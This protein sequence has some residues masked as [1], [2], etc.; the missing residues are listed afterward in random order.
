MRRAK[1]PNRRT[2]FLAL[3]SDARRVKRE[4][5]SSLLKK[6][7]SRL[8]SI[9][10]FART[11]SPY[12]RQLYRDLPARIV[13]P[14]QLPVTNKPK[15]MA[16]FDDW[17]TDPAV[18][19]EQ[20]K[21]FADNPDLIGTRFLGRYSFATTSGTT[22]RRG[23]FLMDDP[24]LAVRNALLWRAVSD[25]LNL[26][27]GLQLLGRGLRT[28]V[29]LATGG[30]FAGLSGATRNGKGSP[31]RER[32]V[33]VFSVSTPLP[34]LVRGLNA[35]RP[36]ILVGY[37]TILRLLA[38]E[39]EGDRL[40]LEPLLVLPVAEGLTSDE[41]ERL[42]RV[43]GCKVRTLYAATECLHVAYS[44]EHGWL[45]LNS[46][47]LVL[48]PVDDTY[49]PVPPGETSHTVLVSNLANYLQ[50]I[51][52]YD[53]GDSVV[54]RPELCECGNPLP[55]IRVQGRSADLL[56]FADTQGQPLAL[57]PLVL[58]SLADRTPGV[59]LF[60]LVQTSPTALRLRVM[61]EAG[62]DP[63]RV[64][65]TLERELQQL[66]AAHRLA[67]VSIEQAE[68]FPEPSPGGKYRMVI[69]LPRGG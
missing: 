23:I 54:V 68:E 43:F 64:K 45:H 17:A 29:I 24:T 53:L 12:Y 44:C 15:L 59:E 1:V 7:Q 25:W 34:E 9:V 51:L 33:R 42:A 5:F 20:A 22:G 48:E 3:L 61:P 30:H 27:D 6:Q 19:L 62:A 49:Q 28:A 8:E 32:A 47:W 55:A 52:R 21:R 36:A 35:F 14:A 10:S 67:H 38:S 57:P 4:G 65:Q 58:S 16:H 37:A 46:D 41:Y 63:L 60:Q 40:R 50:P 2:R 18:T 56:R 31:W 13:S 11:H 39:Q 26:T 69:P 66:F